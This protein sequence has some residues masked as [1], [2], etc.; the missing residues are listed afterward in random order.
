MNGYM[1]EGEQIEHVRSFFSRYGLPIL[2]LLI[3]VAV[4]GGGYWGY[5][6]YQQ[7]QNEAASA[8]FSQLA[9][10]YDKKDAKSARLNAAKLINSYGGTHYAQLAQIYLARMDFD[11]GQLPQAQAR[12]QRLKNENLPTGFAQVVSLG[13]GRIALAQNKPADALKA[14]QQPAAGQ[15][16][17]EYDELKGDAYAALKRPADARKAY[18]QALAEME[19]N[20]PYRSIIQLKLE[21]IGG[22]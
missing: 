16:A 12:L 6:R 18:Q 3:V 10:Q 14:L 4:A 5:Q 15:Y 22:S 13:L 2:I 7:H 9:Q 21:Q 8:I 19:P 17:S 20:D 1:T 11:A